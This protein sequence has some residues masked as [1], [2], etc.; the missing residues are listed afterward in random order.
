MRSQSVMVSLVSEQAMPNVMAALLMEPRPEV[1]VCIL[2]EDRDE[3]GSTDKEYRRVCEGIRRAFDIL[4]EDPEGDID[5][6]VE[7]RRPVS[8]YDFVEVQE[9]CRE[10]REEYARQGYRVVYNV[11]GGTKL[12]A[13][14]ALEDARRGGC[15]A[16]YVDTEFRKLV[17]VTP[18]ARKD[19][20]VEERL[21]GLDVPHYLAAYGLEQIEGDQD[22]PE[23]FKQAAREL[24]GR[25]E[26]GKAV[27]ELVLREERR[28]DETCEVSVAGLEREERELLDRVAEC[29]GEGAQILPGKATLRLDVDQDMYAFWWGRRWLEWYVFSVLE[30]LAKDREDDLRYN[31]PWC[32]VQFRWE[33]DFAQQMMR[34]LLVIEEKNEKPIPLPLNELDVTAV[35]GGRLLVCECKTGKR[36]LRSEHFYKLGVLGRRL[37]TFADIV[38]VTDVE[39]LADRSCRDKAVRRQT[40]RALTLD[41]VVVGLK[42]L[43][44][45]DR[46]LAEPDR[47]LRRQKSNFGLR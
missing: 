15:R 40:V 33:T 47:Q 12:M 6:R 1:V 35:R 24:A 45:L 5:V 3:A 32:D 42:E 20:F 16:V 7:S 37:G 8:P 30:E 23:Q 14:A 36:A 31:G 17:E 27:V 10:V 26:Q 25:P 29:L 18:E 38:F 44:A 2:P 11:T 41:V 28:I 43:P 39:G 34:H 22:I 4:G 19:E 21:R 13:Q 9:K 46:I